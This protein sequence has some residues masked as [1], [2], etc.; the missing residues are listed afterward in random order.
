MQRHRPSKTERGES[1]TVPSAAG[2]GGGGDVQGRTYV[3]VPAAYYSIPSH[4]V[5]PVLTTVLLQ[6]VVRVRQI[7]GR[8]RVDLA[9]G[10]RWR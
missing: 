1:C 3:L 8:R 5:V 10:K 9:E 4:V 6:P 7:A 2:G